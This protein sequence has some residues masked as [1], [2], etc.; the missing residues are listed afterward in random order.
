MRLPWGAANYPVV[1]PPATSTQKEVGL[2]TSR[3]YGMTGSVGYFTF[4]EANTVLDA[5]TN[6]YEIS[7]QST[8][9]GIETSLKIDPYHSWSI[10]GAGLYFVSAMQNAPLDNTINGRIPENTPRLAGSLF[11]TYRPDFV[12]GLA[13][14]G[15]VRYS[16]HKYVNPQNQASLDAYRVLDVNAAYTTRLNGR[17]AT[18]TFG[19]NNLLDDHYWSNAAEGALGI[20]A[21]RTFKASMK[22]DF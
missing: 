1:L 21:P 13:L 17:K 2:R 9:K 22:T 11:G 14:T 12:E 5:V 3:L 7:G 16:A 6:V 10:N 15:G 19:V 18:F 4:T 8:F 20:G